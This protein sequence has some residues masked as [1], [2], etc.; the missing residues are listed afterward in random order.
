MQ[1]TKKIGL[2]P[3]ALVHIG[4]ENL[5]KSK[6]SL[7]DF[8]DQHFVEKE[9]LQV[10]EIKQYLSKSTTTWVNVYGLSDIDTIEK[11]G[12]LFNL[13]TLL[14]EDVLNT[15]HRPKYENFEDCLYINF[16]MIGLNN[17]ETDINS[18]QI[19]LVLGD[20][21]V[22]SF[23]EKEGDIFDAFRDRIRENKLT[24]RKRPADYIFY[25]LI[26]MVVDNY[27]IINEFL[28]DRLDQ[29]EER[30]ET[31]ISEDLAAEIQSLKKKIMSFRKSCIPLRD[32]VYSIQ[33]DNSVL[34]NDTTYRFINDVYEHLVQ[35]I[36]SIDHQRELL[37]SI[38]DMYNTAMSN[39]M[40]KV[41]QLLTIIATI[42]IPLTFVAGIYGMN[43]EN[44]PELK[45][46]FGYPA[47]WILMSLI[48]V[49]MLIFFRRK[50]WL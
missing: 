11:I 32:S 31:S 42:F 8:Q 26:D 34:I 6:V 22:I 3:G 5:T 38:M 48:T 41:M 20:N 7:I 14:L 12:H 43:F 35:L 9:I 45:W 13:D 2:P 47:V 40:N 33:K 16:K 18:E 4:T 15:Q 1:S 10:D 21:W 50:R 17:D 19:S 25:R 23:Q 49:V 28:N 46:P 36:E 37:A 30:V 29:L 27:L 44:M 24:A 39:R